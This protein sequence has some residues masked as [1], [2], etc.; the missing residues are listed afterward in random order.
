MAE[1][2]ASYVPSKTAHLNPLIDADSLIYRAGWTGV[3]RLEDGSPTPSPLSHSLSNLKTIMVNILDRFPHR[4]YDRVFL[5][6]SGGFRYKVAT[7]KPYKSTRS[8]KKPEHFTAMREY[9]IKHFGAEVVDEDIPE[10]ERREADDAVSSIQW[11]HPE[12]STCIVSGDKDL[13][14]TPGWLYNP[15]K[16]TF[17]C[18]SLLDAD[19][20]FWRQVLA[21]DSVD[22]IPGLRGVGDKTAVKIIESC[23]RKRNRVRKATEDL[24]K[25]EFSGRWFSALDEIATLVFMQR[26]PGMTWQH[27]HWNRT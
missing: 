22:A 26:D 10:D 27:Y 17:E 23:S 14:Q 2:I 8:A 4:E 21:G 13:K 15:V 16:D 9:L 12:K 20:F 3:E 19:L 7:L 5:T 18:R 24:Y 25:K 1:I 11:A 6:P